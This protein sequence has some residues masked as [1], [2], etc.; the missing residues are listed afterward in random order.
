MATQRYDSTD[1]RLRGRKAQQRRER[2]WARTPR[3]ASCGVLTCPKGVGG[4]AFNL[5]H[6]VPL[7]KGGPDTDANCQVLC[8]PCHDRKTARDMGHRVNVA[9]GIDGWPVNQGG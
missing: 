9:I 2:I 8:I 3:C 4:Q 1:G 7:F 5:D 6:R